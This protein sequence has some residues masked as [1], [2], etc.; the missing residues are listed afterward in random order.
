VWM[1]TKLSDARF[2]TKY[3]GRYTKRPPMSES[4]I[5]EYNG[6][7]VVFEYVDKKEG[8]HR[9][10]TLPV[11]QFIG[12]LIRHIHDKHYRAVR[13][14]GIY[15]N[16][17]RK[18]DVENARELLHEKAPPEPVVLTWRERRKR[19]NGYD[20]LECHFCKIE[21]ILVKIVYPS[22]RDGPMLER[23]F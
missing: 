17:T 10:I 1:G 7:T 2:T 14:A 8:V 3:I 18:T 16:R 21:L 23:V 20:P 5:K 6:E 9:T 4:R 22:S 11:E 12:R 13:Y 15:S 19:Q